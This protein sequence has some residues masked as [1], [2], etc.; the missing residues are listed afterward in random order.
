MHEDLIVHGGQ[1]LRQGFPVLGAEVL[2]NKLRCLE[3]LKRGKRT[4]E[5]TTFFFLGVLLKPRLRASGSLSRA[6]AAAIPHALRC[7]FDHARRA[8]VYA[9]LPRTKAVGFLS[10]SLI[11]GQRASLWWGR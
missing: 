6:V 5:A 8:L 2:V 1:L 9:A 7:A 10:L 3:Q 11:R 4:T